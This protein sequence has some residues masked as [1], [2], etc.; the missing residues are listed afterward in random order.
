[1]EKR[2]VLE[3]FK[4]LCGMLKDVEL[5]M[6]EGETEGGIVFPTGNPDIEEFYI[7]FDMNDLHKEW[8]E[9][10][11]EFVGM[12]EKYYTE[13]KKKLEIMSLLGALNGEHYI[14]IQCKAV[15]ID[16]DADGC[17]DLPTE[18]ILPKGIGLNDLEEAGDYITDQTG[19]C[20]NGFEVEP[21]A[22]QI[23]KEELK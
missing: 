9:A 21:Y 7:P 14:A 1:M 22:W 18:I 11:M 23:I 6:R 20:H 13:V 12:I 17:A 16:W 5:D 15:N 8:V 2:E 19:F 10:Q 4:L 3:Q